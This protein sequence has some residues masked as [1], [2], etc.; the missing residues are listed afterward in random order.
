MS[1]ANKFITVLGGSGYVG[2]H[3]IY[4]LLKNTSHKVISISRSGKIDL[5][6]YKDL[7]E[8]HLSRLE[9][10]KGSAL[11]EI[12]IKDSLL[13]SSGVIH[14]IG[15]LISLKKDNEE[16]SYKK[17]CYETAFIPS[18]ILKNNN[19][20][21]KTNFVYISAERGLTFPLSLLF[22]GYIKYKREA[23]K[24]LLENQNINAYILKP[25]VICD[26]KIRS[27]SVPLYK[28][29]NILNNIEKNILPKNLNL[30]ECMNLPSQGTMLDILAD[31]AVKG[32]SGEL[33]KNIY[34]ANELI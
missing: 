19:K 25:G 5:S 24:C 13:K 8:Q 21:E 30:G 10:I 20:R 3:C 33:E 6:I 1:S 27:W 12:D 4:K 2:K 26:P 22:D 34:K 7:N 32:A 23:E 17:M 29:V 18:E 14:S 9:N 15:T 16:G 28:G 11:K 31:Y